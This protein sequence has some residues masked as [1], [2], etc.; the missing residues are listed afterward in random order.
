MRGPD[1]DALESKVGSKYALVVAVAKRAE[2][3]KAGARPLVPCTSKNAVAIALEEIAQREVLV[4]PEGDELLAAQA[5]EPTERR[6]AGSEE[7]LE[8]DLDIDLDSMLEE[9]E[10]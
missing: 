5:E 1:L 7:E 4:G 8:M 2:Q 3:L 9:G 10:E 6:E